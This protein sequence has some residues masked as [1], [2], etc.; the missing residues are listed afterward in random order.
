MQ[1]GLSNKS[2]FNFQWPFIIIENGNVRAAFCNMFVFLISH[3][4][5]CSSPAYTKVMLRGATV[6]CSLFNIKQRT[7]GE[8]VLKSAPADL[9]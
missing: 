5:A 1:M 2:Y 8:Q 4:H 6:V 9:Q 7:R 3:P